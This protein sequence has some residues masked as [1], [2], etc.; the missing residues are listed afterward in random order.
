MKKLHFLIILNSAFLILNSFCFAQNKSIDSLL[1]LLKKDKQ[2][3]NKV[4]HLNALAWKL[5]SSNPDTA[6]I[7]GKQALDII[8]PVHSSEFTT[9]KERTEGRRIMALRANVLGNLGYYY[10]LIADY[11]IAIDYCL[12]ALKINEELKNKSGIAANL[13]NISIVYD[14]QGDYPKALGYYLQTLKI[15]EELGNKNDIAVQL[16]NIGFVYWNEGD[17]TKALDY[18]F[19]ALKMAEELGD[20]QLQ[21]NTLGNIA[22]EYDNQGDY[23]KALNY[24]FKALKIN[25]ELGNKDGIA[26]HLG[27]IGLVYTDQADYS[28]ALDYYLKA[29]KID[30]ELGNKNGIAANFCNIGNLYSKKKKYSIAA[31]YFFKSLKMAEELGEI[32]GIAM[33]LG[34]IGLLYTKTGKF[35]EAEQYLK[36][37][38]SIDDSIGTM[39]YLRQDYQSLSQLYDT[40]GRYKLALLYYKKATELKDTLFSQENKKQL[41]RKEMNYEF[42]KKEAATKATH[43]KEMAVAEAEKK[44]QQFILLLFSCFLLLVFVFAGF[45]FRSLRITRKQKNIIELQKNEV[46]QQK[47]IVEKQKEKIVD[48]IT[49]AQRIQQSILMEES[50]IQN[51]LPECFIYFQPKDIVSGDFYWCSKIDDK[52]ILAAVDCTGHGVPGAFMSMIGNTLLNQIVNEKH[53]TKPSEILRQLNLGVYE[54]LH[55]GKDGA[56]SDD[57]MDIALCT[58]DY[59]NNE[60]QYGGAQNPLFVVYGNQINVIKAD[61]HGI[62]GGGKIAKIHDPIKKEFTNHV[63][64][65][66]KGMSIYLFSDGY[67]DQFGGSNNKK[68]GTQKFKELLLSMQHLSMEKQKVSIKSAHEE[69]KGSSQQIDDILVIGVKLN[70]HVL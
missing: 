17:Y 44:K 39:D 34:N 52:I 43:D 1:I 12:K 40:T 19:K 60:V 67:I 20:K 54:A 10:Y 69:W 3:T 47:E 8:T 37:A 22:I 56:L 36:R 26:V 29:L 32:N 14:D 16:G 62:G 51:Y 61:I 64:P 57:G 68:F 35:K 27:N 15:Y 9:T 23:P 21:A 66:K 65:I 28:R 53:I 50:E 25:E 58:I 55:Q 48:S 18:N 31:D 13:A 7:L 6:I 41:V 59:I 38:V 45:V 49:Y 30:E 24:F 5:G 33:N 63:I 42:D 4:K 46:S 11:S 2:D 70:R